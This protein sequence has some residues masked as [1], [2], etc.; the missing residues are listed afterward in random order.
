MGGL[1]YT[2]QLEDWIVIDIKGALIFA[3]RVKGESMELEFND[4]HHRQPA[5]DMAKGDCVVTRNDN[6]KVTFTLCKG[7]VNISVLCLFCQS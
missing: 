2:D 4:G 5:C 7:F 3:L 1:F 6:G